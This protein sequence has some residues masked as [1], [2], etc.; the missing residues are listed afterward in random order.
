MQEATSKLY[1]NILT[2]R[3]Q[4]L[5]LTMHKAFLSGSYC[6]DYE[7]IVV[8]MNCKDKRQCQSLVYLEV[9]LELHLSTFRDTFQYM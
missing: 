7:Y 5:L 9:D 6:G 3:W 8:W 2:G 1:V 4:G